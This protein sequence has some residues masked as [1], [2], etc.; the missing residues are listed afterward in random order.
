MVVDSPCQ[1]RVT[2]YISDVLWA[3][4]NDLP[5][6]PTDGLTVA[7]LKEAQAI[8]TEIDTSPD[9]DIDIPPL[10]E[11]P[12]A[13]ML[14]IVPEPPPVP[15]D[16]AAMRSALEETD[17]EELL[18]DLVHYRCA[19]DGTMLRQLQNGTIGALA[20][21]T[22]RVLAALLSVDRAQLLANST[23]NA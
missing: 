2:N 5:E 7:E 10:A 23:K 13:V 8:L 20:P 22:V 19:V 17:L 21:H 6:P 15:I 11:D 1:E 16:A 3:I 4:E 18:L 14:G 12:T 9:F